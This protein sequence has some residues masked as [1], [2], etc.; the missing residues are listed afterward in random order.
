M[1]NTRKISLREI[2]EQCGVTRM[3]VSL[4]LRNKPGVSE[5][6]R[7]QVLK[8]AKQ[9][10]YEPDPEVAKLMSRIRAQ[11]PA[12]A[13]ACLALL[14]S[15][16]QPEE[17]MRSVTERKYVEGAIA[18]AR[19]YGY[20]VE[21]FWRNEPGLSPERL[22]SILWNRGIEGI[23]IAPLQ[24]LLPSKQDRTVN[25]DYPLFSVVEISETVESPDLDRSIHD[26]YTSMLKLLETLGTLRYQRMGLVLQTELDERVNGK[27]TAAFLR[28]A[29]LHTDLALPP[30]LLLPQIDQK[31]FDRWWIKHQPDVLVSVDRFGLRM[32]RQHGLKI[33]SDIGY[34]SLDIDGD[35]PDVNDPSGVDQNSRLVGAAA[36]DLLVAAMHRGQRGIPEHPLRMEIEG[37][38][39]LGK[40][41]R[42][43][44]ASKRS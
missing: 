16:R 2:A 22:S 8:V 44:A 19:E 17:W 11:S 13:R 38:V 36:T 9:M 37:T 12:E 43:P 10:G 29:S 42:A 25:L 26:Q 7:K 39:H 23:I 31:A 40:T 35:M 20:R 32:A 3:A 4:A 18:R 5:A 41:T 14:T 33:P 1:N 34:A 15:G 21:E 24:G 28:Y 30:P 27:W 6:T